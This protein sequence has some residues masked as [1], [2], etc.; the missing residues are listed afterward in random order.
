MIV[1]ARVTIQHDLCSD[2]NS[3][4]ITYVYLHAC[5]TIS[6]CDGPDGLC[7]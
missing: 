5:H 6:Q 2:H 3:I 1:A 7:S 4:Y